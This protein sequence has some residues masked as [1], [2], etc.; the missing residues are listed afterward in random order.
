MHSGSDVERQ[1]VRARPAERTAQGREIGDL[2]KTQEVP[3]FGQMPRHVCTGIGRKIAPH[4]PLLL[5]HRHVGSG[6]LR[7]EA[8][9][10][11]IGMFR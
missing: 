11:E 6:S 8:A 3:D 9:V 7:R 5:E 4:L 1:P 2:C 10:V